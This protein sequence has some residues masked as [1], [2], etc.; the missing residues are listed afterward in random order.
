[1]KIKVPGLGKKSYPHDLSR[2]GVTTSSFGFVQPMQ[3]REMV[4]GDH[5]QCRVGESVYLQP[6]EKPTFGRVLVK[7]YFGYVPYE[8][9][10]HPF[11]SLL[12]GKTYSGAIASYIP[13]EV[14]NL[15]NSFWTLLAYLHSEISYFTV[16]DDGTISIT[17]TTV[18]S[19]EQEW[20]FNFSVPAATVSNLQSYLGQFVASYNGQDLDGQS[21][22]SLITYF[23]Q[24]KVTTWC[25]N[26]SPKA[27]EA[28]DWFV[29]YRVAGSPVGLIAGRFT[30]AGKNLRKILIGSGIQLNLA[31][32]EPVSICKVGAYYKFWF[33]NFA[34]QR[35]VSWKNT[36][37]YNFMEYLEQSGT[38]A[39]T[40]V[41]T[42]ILSP[43]TSSFVKWIR[44]LTKCYYTSNP[45]Y[46]SAHIVG[47]SISEVGQDRFPTVASF[48][49]TTYTNTT[50]GTDQGQPYTVPTWASSQNRITQQA[51]DVLQQLYKYVNIR[52]AVGGRI[53]DF[54]RSLY[55]ADYRDEKES[56]YIGSSQFN[57]DIG[58]ILSSA[59]TS[60]GYLGEFAGVGQGTDPGNM[61][62]Y[63]TNC[64]GFFVAL[65]CIVPEAR[66]A[67]GNDPD[68]FHIKKFDFYNEMFD[69][70]TLLPTRR[71]V[72]YNTFS[73]HDSQLVQ[74]G[75]SFGNIPNY[76]EY[77]INTDLIN[78]DV[79]MPSTMNSL[80]PYSL[81]KILPYMNINKF[82]EIQNVDYTDI[83]AGDA[84]R[85]V[86]RYRTLGNYDRIF[87]NSYSDV[88]SAQK[89]G[90]IL[91]EE[92][93]DQGRL[94]D[95]FI[96]YFY[97]ELK[98]H[99]SCLP[100]S[101]S[102]QTDGFGSAFKVEK[103]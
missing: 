4:A 100:M 78:G 26:D 41:G 91:D 2:Q 76:S 32:S 17:G 27:I 9:L 52:T 83:V 15:T 63:N 33:D 54:M 8:D 75:S 49:G 7:N 99:N 19:S 36:Y 86:G 102:F 6:L 48:G 97:L 44:A 62:D 31:N 30:E 66:M 28:Y 90:D 22:I 20:A 72:V 98:S 10:Y 3:V 70:K 103:A 14:P 61:F 89:S 1:M 12:A 95:N 37:F 88:Y 42:Q 45:D 47:T 24:Q 77:K 68:V 93:L 92:W 79:S 65:M 5:F 67:Q 16:P 96:V 57:I 84:W 29:V 74:Q 38:A 58:R 18:I 13:T 40:V 21:L 53:R 82:A 59:E 73:C 25:S 80:L 43:G 34:V 56:S 71:S 69:A 39:D 11:A 23:Q 55:G 46:I 51:L 87:K 50:T 60:E 81:A 64:P 101:E 85:Y 94:D 35:N